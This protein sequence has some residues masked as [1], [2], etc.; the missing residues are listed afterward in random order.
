MKY[1]FKLL[2]N[3]S[4]FCCLV[5]FKFG[6]A[7]AN[8]MLDVYKIKNN[9]SDEDVVLEKGTVLNLLL[10]SDISSGK[11]KVIDPVE[12]KIL[13]NN[14]LE[15]K[16]SGL[17]SMLTKGGRFS[18]SGTVTLS[19]NKIFLDDGIE[20][21]LIARSGEFKAAFPP[22]ANTGTLNLARTITAF[23]ITASP[24]TFGASLG[25]GFLISGLLSAYKNGVSDFFWGGLDGSG[26]SFLENM[27]RKQ[28]DLNLNKGIVIP[29]VLSEDL[30]IPINIEKENISDHLNVNDE[31]AQHKLEQLLKWGDLT[32]ALEYSVKTQ[33][34]TFYE[35]LI[36][37]ISS[38]K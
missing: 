20:Y 17:V 10:L 7:F 2:L 30:K 11:N 29:V 19:T 3:F 34:K 5:L 16:A 9:L 24:L 36:S 25:A 22:H 21:P 14:G 32:G 6:P 4:L 13:N 37:D 26:L 33:Q 27:F 15:I 12:F 23:S 31:I 8:E 38:N 28:P 18:D 1:R 35:K